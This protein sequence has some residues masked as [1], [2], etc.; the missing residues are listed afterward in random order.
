MKGDFVDAA[1][2]GLGGPAATDS[3]DVE[4]MPNVLGDESSDS[5]GGGDLVGERVASEGRSRPMKAP[6]VEESEDEYKD[7]PPPT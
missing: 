4:P 1:L 6:L 2:Q 7:G 3:P 5:D